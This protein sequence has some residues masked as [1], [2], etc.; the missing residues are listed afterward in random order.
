MGGSVC[1][2]SELGQGAEFTINLKTESQVTETKSYDSGVPLCRFGSFSLDSS[3]SIQRKTFS[4][5]S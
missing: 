5:V 3:N 4:F 1:V 2:T